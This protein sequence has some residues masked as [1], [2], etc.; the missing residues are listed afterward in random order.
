[1]LVNNT[2]SQTLA[3]LLPRRLLATRCLSLKLPSRDRLPYTSEIL[4][5]IHSRGIR[6][7]LWK[8]QQGHRTSLWS[9]AQLRGNYLLRLPQLRW[10]AP[11][12]S[13]HH[14]T[15]PTGAGSTPREAGTPSLFRGQ[16]GTGVHDLLVEPSLALDEEHEASGLAADFGSP[17]PCLEQ[18]GL[19][20][21]A[22]DLAAEGVVVG[23]DAASGGS[24]AVAPPP[25]G[26]PMP[27]VTLVIMRE[28]WDSVPM[29]VPTGQPT[30]HQPVSHG[31]LAEELDG[32]R[33]SLVEEDSVIY[34]EDAQRGA[35]PATRASSRAQRLI[36]LISATGR[37][38]V[39]ASMTRISAD[40]AVSS[41]S[42]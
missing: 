34:E 6:V 40:G 30:S 14:L 39:P 16:A 1:M 12:L 21:L 20:P 31:Q 42:H 25:Y 23:A 28:T 24:Q 19:S 5:G 2:Y 38:T 9:F 27:H 22:A 33:E 3:G 11:F 29:A 4:A 35:E 32:E 8:T 7:L 13:H 36:R 17:S 41:G 10:T 26:A 15:M 37:V 18:A